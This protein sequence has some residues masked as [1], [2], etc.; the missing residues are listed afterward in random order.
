MKIDI[1]IAE[2]NRK[3]VGKILNELLS[4]EYLLYTKTLGFHWN[5]Q[6]KQFHDLHEFF[7]DLYEQLFDINDEVAERARQLG[8]FSFGSMSEFLKNT[9]LEEKPGYHPEALTMISLMLADHEDII[10]EIRLDLIETEELEDAGTNN[11]LT[12]IM[13]R[14]EKMAWMLRAHL[15]K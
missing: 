4:N 9:T 2:K 15:S 7:K 5:V 14:H 6:G 8:V 11:F 13:E 1:G 10:K 12:E 3:Q